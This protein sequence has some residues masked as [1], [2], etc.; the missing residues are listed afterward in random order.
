M[1]YVEAYKEYFWR[2]KV[3]KDGEGNFIKWQFIE[4]LGRLQDDEGLHLENKLRK[5][6][7]NFFQTENEGAFGSSTI[8]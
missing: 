2:K 3:L 5:R 1:S 6:H 7:P 8:E 4:N